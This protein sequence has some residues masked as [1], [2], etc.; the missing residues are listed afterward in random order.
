MAVN[1]SSSDK[2]LIKTYNPLLWAQLPD[3]RQTCVPSFMFGTLT[4]LRIDGSFRV[5]RAGV[6]GLRKRRWMS[7][8]VLHSDHGQ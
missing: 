5:W 7:M 6:M 4:S 3:L 1:E 2:D 8:P